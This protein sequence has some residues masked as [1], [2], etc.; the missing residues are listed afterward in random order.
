MRVDMKQ[1]RPPRAFTATSTPQS[2]NRLRTCATMKNGRRRRTPSCH[3]EAAQAAIGIHETPIRCCDSWIPVSL[4]SGR[5]TPELT[6]PVAPRQSPS[7]PRAVRVD[8]RDP[9]RISR[10]PRAAPI[11]AQPITMAFAPSDPQRAA[12]LDHARKR[13]IA[14]DVGDRQ[15]QAARP[16]A[17]SVRPFAADSACGA[18]S[19]VQAIAITPSARP[20]QCGEICR[21]R[22]C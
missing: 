12:D 2:A 20:A 14:R 11:P 8:H 21:I 19:S 22:R 15:L 3:P 6:A 9:Q 16:R 10:R 5:V 18:R 4:R 7:S 13:L 17:G 1:Y